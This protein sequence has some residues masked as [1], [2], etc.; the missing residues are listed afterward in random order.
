MGLDRVVQLG[1]CDRVGLFC[2]DE[3]GVGLV[4]EGLELLGKLS[5]V[6]G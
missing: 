1:E 3:L 5:V 2:L 6:V 4:L